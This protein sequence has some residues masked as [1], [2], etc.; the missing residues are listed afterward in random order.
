MNMNNIHSKKCWV[1][2]NPILGHMDK[3]KHLK[4]LTQWLGLSIFDP[5]VDWVKT[6]HHFLEFIY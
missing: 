1:V 6:T 5:M 2:F 3:L 4:N